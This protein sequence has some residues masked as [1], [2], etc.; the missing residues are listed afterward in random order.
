M[1]AS[2]DEL[3]AAAQLNPRDDS[4]QM[5]EIV[6]RFD[7]LAMKVARGLTSRAA[8]RE[9]LAN[10]ARLALVRAVRR[11]DLA[12]VGFPHYAEKFMR[13]AASREFGQWTRQSSKEVAEHNADVPKDPTIR[14]DTSWIMLPWSWGEG[15]VA[16]IVQLLAPRNQ[17]L[18]HE[19]YVEDR[20]LADI[21]HT[22][23]TTESAVSQR[24]RTVHRMVATALAV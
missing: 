14:L 1:R 8:L 5:D 17:Q 24:L 7:C 22:G 21:A 4:P 12:R 16:D 23:S 6:R 19:R 18:L 13:G 2:L 11:H 10:A 3:I 20:L 9:D 15:Q